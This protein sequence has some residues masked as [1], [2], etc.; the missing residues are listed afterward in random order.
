MKI[1][2]LEKK[3]S[4]E[5]EKLYIDFCQKRQQL[6]F[7]VASKQLKNVREVRDVR[8]TIARILTIQKQRQSEEKK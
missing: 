8:K 1:R 6:N 5:L 4:E 3:S 7:K 2:E